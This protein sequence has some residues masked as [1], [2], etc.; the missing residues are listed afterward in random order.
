MNNDTT[1]L[2]NLV[3][4][5][6]LSY[7]CVEFSDFLNDS[8][9]KYILTYMGILNYLL[10]SLL[11]AEELIEERRD[12]KEQ[13]TQLIESDN[14]KQW[15]AQTPDKNI[16]VDVSKGH[17][18]A[19]LKSY[20]SKTACDLEIEQLTDDIQLGELPAGGDVTNYYL[21]AASL[22]STPTRKKQRRKTKTKTQKTISPQRAKRLTQHRPDYRQESS[23]VY[24]SRDRVNQCLSEL[25]TLGLFKVEQRRKGDSHKLTEFSQM[26]IYQ[27]LNFYKQCEES[28]L[29]Y[30]DPNQRFSQLPQHKGYLMIFAYNLVFGVTSEAVESTEPISLSAFIEKIACQQKHNS[31][32]SCE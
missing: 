10:H 6:A 5:P 32:T 13:L 30:A 29:W 24:V 28:L 15:L 16:S 21:K 17:I 23:R 25:A 4:K 18:C 7:P 11:K 8:N 9:K 3:D 31:P 19:Y 27:I 14:L 12:R 2:S 26:D 1:T 22:S 20:W